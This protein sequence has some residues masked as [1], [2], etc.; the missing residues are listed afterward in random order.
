MQSV[1]FSSGYEPVFEVAITSQLLTEDVMP[2]REGKDTDWEIPQTQ[3]GFSKES[4]THRTD[5]IGRKRPCFCHAP[6]LWQG[7]YAQRQETLSRCCLFEADVENAC[8]FDSVPGQLF[9]N[10]LLFWSC[11]NVRARN[12]ELWGSCE[13]WQVLA[14]LSAAPGVST[15]SPHSQMQ[16]NIRLKCGYSLEFAH[17]PNYWL[18][19]SEGCLLTRT[20]TWVLIPDKETRVIIAIA[21]FVGGRA[22]TAKAECGRTWGVSTSKNNQWGINI[23]HVHEADGV[24]WWYLRCGRRWLLCH[25]CFLAPPLLSHAISAVLQVIRLVR[26]WSVLACFYF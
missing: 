3:N 15:E 7:T 21:L 23:S 18:L 4:L 24:S 8:S 13:S 14:A 16:K 17:W 6:L 25:L 20:Q 2:A 19:G 5:E 26:K 1:L 11:L 9:N 12:T 22:C 10:T